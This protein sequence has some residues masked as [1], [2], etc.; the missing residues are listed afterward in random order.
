MI[1]NAQANKTEKLIIPFVP[2]NY[3]HPFNLSTII[4]DILKNHCNHKVLLFDDISSITII[5][6]KYGKI[7]SIFSAFFKDKITID[8]PQYQ[9]TYN[10]SPLEITDNFLRAINDFKIPLTIDLHVA[11]HEE[12]LDLQNQLN[13][14]NI[15]CPCCNIKTDG[16]L[17]NCSKYIFQGKYH[18]NNSKFHLHRKFK[19]NLS[20]TYSKIELT[21]LK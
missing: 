12:Y 7:V 14:I 1:S 9:L 2:H 21:K 10:L 15:M 5:P 17:H 11:N 16:S 13:N 6:S 20:L 18:C 4:S 8:T 19:F 3:I